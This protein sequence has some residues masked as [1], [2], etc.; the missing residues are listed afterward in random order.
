MV[1]IT[2]KTVLKIAK[3]SRIDIKP[4][5]TDAISQKLTHI[6]AWIEKLN[7]VNVDNIEPMTCVLP[8][9]LKMR[10]DIVTDGGYPDI[11]VNNAPI[12]D[13]NFFCVPKVVE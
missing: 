7:T 4:Q 1:D 6:M 11:I 2:E 5:E 9:P 12:K 10:Q 8:M 3:L 13:G